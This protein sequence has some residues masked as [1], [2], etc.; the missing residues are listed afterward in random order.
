MNGESSQKRQAGV[1]SGGGM[2]G[3]SVGKRSH[4]Y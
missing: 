3:G 4:V 2:V 1:A